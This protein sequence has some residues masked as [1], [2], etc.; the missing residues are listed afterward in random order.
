MKESDVRPQ[1][2]HVTRKGGLQRHYANMF[3]IDPTDA[4]MLLLFSQM[5]SSAGGRVIEDRTEITM[6]MAAFKS[7]VKWGAIYV[8]DYERRNGEIKPAILSDPV[9]SR[10]EPQ[11]QEALKEKSSEEELLRA[12]VPGAVQ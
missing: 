12:E 4:D 9:F 10:N 1:I 11:I 5:V 6:P 7:L 8:A 2:E 3:L